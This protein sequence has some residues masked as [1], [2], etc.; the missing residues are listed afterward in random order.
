MYCR[1]N[2]PAI[3]FL[4]L[5]IVATVRAGSGLTL[6]DFRAHDPFILADEASKTYYLYTSV[7]NGA[8]PR[9]KSGVVAF[10]ST[11]LK[12]WDGPHL[13]FSVPENGWAN[14]AHGAWAP[15]VHI[16]NGKYYLFVTLHNE[17]K[18]IALPPESWR[19]TH[20][21]GTQIFVSESPQGPFTAIAD[22]PATPADMMTLDGTLYIEDGKPWLVYCHEWIQVIDGTFEARELKPDL[23]GTIGNTMLLFR[24]SDAPWITPWQAMPGDEPREFVSDGPFFYRTSTGRLLM[25]WSSWLENKQYCQTLAY[26]LSGRLAGPWRQLPP[27]LTDHS[28][29]GMIFKT[30]DDRLMLV[31]HNPT[32]SPES[33]A[34]I[35]DLVDTGDTVEISGAALKQLPVQK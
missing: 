35:Y 28:G 33:R 7:N 15:E 24:A 6:K 32:M 34:T 1:K 4:F 11:D 22:S 2:F 13:V 14:T 18:V 30:F 23:S 25:L 29:H 12:S 31:V 8:L 16:Y 19:K 3:V 9:G 26:S 10:K 5:F 17:D 27:L 21:R 20:A